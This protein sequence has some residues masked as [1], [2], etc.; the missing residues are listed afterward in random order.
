[1]YPFVI[2]RFPWSRTTTCAL[3]CTTTVP[4]S[5]LYCRA[6]RE[7]HFNISR[8]FQPVNVHENTAS[9]PC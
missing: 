7:I 9:L 5:L 1:M 8:E 3:R 2:D 6:D 4:W